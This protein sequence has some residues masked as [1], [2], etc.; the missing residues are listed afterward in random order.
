M[1]CELEDQYQNR[2]NVDKGAGSPQDKQNGTNPHIQPKPYRNLSA[3]L[4]S[5]H[6]TVAK[7]ALKLALGAESS[8]GL[9]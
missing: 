5:M 7:N 2:Q 6:K 9:P 1:A 3:K 4:N 8:G